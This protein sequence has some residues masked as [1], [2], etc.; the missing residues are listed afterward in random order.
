MTHSWIVRTS[1]ATVLATLLLTACGGGTSKHAASTSRSSTTSTPG[2]GLPPGVVVAT[3]IPNSV[4]NSP[5]LRKNVTISA[6]QAVDGG[7]SASG[8]AINPGAQ[9]E[10]Y[11]ITVFFTDDAATV[12]DSV[13]TKVSVSPGGHEKW[14]A[15]GKF[16]APAKTL[17]VLRGVG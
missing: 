4:A 14:T 13:E 6:C 12:I 17:C 16:I 11:T 5:A 9:S 2:A 1:A 8:T 3:S 7:W 10:D 15:A